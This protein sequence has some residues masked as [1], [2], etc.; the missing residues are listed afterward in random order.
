MV[1]LFRSR[2]WEECTLVRQTFYTFMLKAYG[3]GQFHNH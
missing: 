1:F 3:I 2:R